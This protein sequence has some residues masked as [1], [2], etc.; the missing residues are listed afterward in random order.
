MAADIR[1]TGGDSVI[2]EM[3]TINGISYFVADDGTG[4]G[5]ELWRTDGTT[6]GTYMVKNI[7]PC[8]Q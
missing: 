2:Y 7:N 5:W 1:T 6:A 8:G 3:V 4:G